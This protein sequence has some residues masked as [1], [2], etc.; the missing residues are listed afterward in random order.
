LLFIF[1]TLPAFAFEPFDFYSEKGVS[2]VVPFVLNLSAGDRT[3]NHCIWN[4]SLDQ[5]AMG[6][7]SVTSAVGVSEEY[8]RC[9]CYLRGI[10]M[11]VMYV[12]I[13]LVVALF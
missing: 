6:L 12:F 11:I 2:R 4:V 3:A 8:Q 13:I 10:S 9:F 1:E 7:P 5:T